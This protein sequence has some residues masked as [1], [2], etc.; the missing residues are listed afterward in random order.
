MNKRVDAN[1]AADDAKAREKDFRKAQVAA[2]RA[3]ET[4]KFAKEKKEQF[5]R[6]MGLIV[7]P[8]N[9]KALI[10][11]EKQLGLS[12]GSGNYSIDEVRKP[13][14]GMGAEDAR[15]VLKLIT[16]GASSINFEFKSKGEEGFIMA[17]EEGK[18]KLHAECYPGTGETQN[19][20][21][22]DFH[23]KAETE[24]F[25]ASIDILLVDKDGKVKKHVTLLERDPTSKS[26]YAGGQYDLSLKDCNW[27]RRRE[28][29]ATCD[30]IEDYTVRFNVQLF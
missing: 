10:K 2:T 20:D 18:W 24:E 6:A 26:V 16:F 29:P 23:L 15:A 11:F 19:F 8:V 28:D 22:L 7:T 17:V 14:E 4:A 3:V 25:M 12:G 9:E 1:T 27:T 30:L 5:S 13:G 21:A